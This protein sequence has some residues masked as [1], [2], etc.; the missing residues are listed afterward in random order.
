MF[1]TIEYKPE[2]TGVGKSC[3]LIAEE[4]ARKNIDV[5]V[6]APIKSKLDKNFEIVNNVKLFRIGKNIHNSF[7]LVKFFMIFISII[8]KFRVCKKI[9]P[10]IIIGET[11]ALE[12]GFTSGLFGKILKIPSFLRVHASLNALTELYN[13]SVFKRK[14]YSQSFKLNSAIFVLH[15]EAKKKVK[16]LFNCDSY[17]LPSCINPNRISK[18]ERQQIKMRFLKEGRIKEDRFNII[19]VGRLI[20]IKGF[21][22]SIKAMRDLSECDLYIIGDGPQKLKLQQ[23]IINYQLENVFLLGLLPNAMV[24]EYMQVCDLYLSSSLSEGL[25]IAQLEAMANGLP[26]ATTMVGAA[27]EIIVHGQNGFLLPTESPKAIV[28]LVR[29]ILKNK[30]KLNQ[31]RENAFSHLL[32]K[33]SCSVI[34]T[35]FLKILSNYLENDN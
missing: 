31:I 7:F 5:Y 10:D 3:S 1:F 35:R 9:N 2:E 20:N 34:A 4:L 18:E 23:L 30:E 17:I 11:W 33:F 25:S 8:K 14:I 19:S 13:Y 24:Q 32:C 6:V 26:V 22:Y 16:I 12:G 28:N 15:H 29:K 21:E 27:S